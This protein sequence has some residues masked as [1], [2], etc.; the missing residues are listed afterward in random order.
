MTAIIKINDWD[1]ILETGRNGTNLSRTLTEKGAGVL[2]KPFPR[3]VELALG[4][5]HT[6][7]RSSPI[8]GI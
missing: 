4:N 1:I 5:V 7:D 3:A 2:P 6:S 8:F